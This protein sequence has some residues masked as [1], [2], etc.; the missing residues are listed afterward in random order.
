MSQILA[1]HSGSVEATSQQKG[2]PNSDQAS[3]G[4]WQSQMKSAVRDGKQLCE[5]LGLSPELACRSAA[6]EFPVFAPMS[7]VARM[8]PEDASDPLLQQVLAR[9]IEVSSKAGTGS[10]SEAAGLPSQSQLPLARSGC[11]DPVGDLNAERAPGLLQK[12]RRRVLMITTGACAVHCRYCF[13]RHYPYDS[14]PKGKSGLQG[15]IDL[16]A[17]DSSIDEV[18]LSGGDPLTLPDERLSWLCS[19]LDDINHVRRIRFHTRVPVVIPQRVC[20]SLLEWVSASRSA[21]FFVLHFNH[22]NEINDSVRQAM[23]EL[24][25][26]GATLLNQA[27]LLCDVNSTWEA[28]RDLCLSLADMQVLPYYLHQLDPVRGAMHFEVSDEEAIAIHARLQAEL[29]GYAVPKLVREIAGMES[30]TPVTEL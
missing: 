18:I 7:Y 26:A 14:V 12:Y 15:S 13:R 28:Q 2:G 9:S 21:M 29:P 16:I 20:E 19:Q 5:L 23:Q 25:K 3:A 4:T 8:K 10:L 1:A 24:R 27:V 22:A 11:E 6:A 17:R 30:K